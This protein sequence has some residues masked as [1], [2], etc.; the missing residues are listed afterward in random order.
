MEHNTFW[1]AVP[2]L[3]GVPPS[4]AILLLRELIGSGNVVYRI[5]CL[6]N[7][8]AYI[9]ESGNVFQ[10]MRSHCSG[11]RRGAHHS[12]RM[13]RA[14]KS[15]GADAFAADVLENCD[16]QTDRHRKA[17]E[18]FYIRTLRPAFNAE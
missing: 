2:K 15:Y 17:R 16:G 10:R 12:H 11:L 9:G 14:F 5:T 6:A 7:G 18:A 13:R 4:F 1:F 3:T 8:E